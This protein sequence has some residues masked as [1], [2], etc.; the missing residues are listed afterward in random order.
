MG[1][2]MG[3]RKKNVYISEQVVSEIIF[4]LY[5]GYCIFYGSVHFISTVRE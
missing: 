2:K 5:T 3:I 1:K 4:Q